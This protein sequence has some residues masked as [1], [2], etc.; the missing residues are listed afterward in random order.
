MLYE[1]ISRVKEERWFEA[2]LEMRDRYFF[3]VELLRNEEWISIGAVDLFHVD[4]K[5]RAVNLGITIGEK[6]YWGQGLGTDATYT[7]LLFAFRELNLNRVELEV[8]EDNL[9]AV[10][11]YEKV[12][13]QH[14]GIRRK[15]FFQDGCYHDVYLMGILQEE[16]LESGKAYLQKLVGKGEG[17][18]K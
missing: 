5:N 11:C 17:E 15:T 7:S 12:G 10:H 14:E 6:T 18:C 9:R 3:I 8:F 13:F 2:L 1:L 4:W 16:F